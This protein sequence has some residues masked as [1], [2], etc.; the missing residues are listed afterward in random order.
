MGKALLL[1]V[2]GAGFALSTQIFSSQESEGRTALAQ[3]NYEEETIAREIAVSAFNVGM[4]DIRERGGHLVA[5][6]QD[7]NGPDF[8]GR[9]GTYTS[10]PYAGS[11][12]TVRAVLTSGQSV[13]LVSTGHTGLDAAT[14]RYRSSY[15]MH[16]EYRLSVLTARERALVNVN[17]IGSGGSYCSAIFYQAFTPG[18]APGTVPVPQLLFPSG[19]RDRR[20]SL[21]AREIQV[22]PGT[23]M[24]F[25]IAVDENCSDRPP[26]MTTCESRAYARSF[27]YDATQYNHT[28]NA[29]VVAAGSLNEAREDIW[30]FIEQ[31]PDNRQ[32][33]RIGWEDIHRS[34]WKTVPPGATLNEL[35]LIKRNGYDGAGWPT[36][37]A[38]GYRLLRDFG[39]KPDFDDQVI[40]VALTPLLSADGQ[41]RAAAEAAAEQTCNPTTTTPTTTTPTPPVPTPPTPAPGTTNGAGCNC[42]GNKKVYV[43]H[44]PP[45]NESNEQRICISESGWTNGH[46]GR[47][48]DYLICRGS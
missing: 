22:E 3:R 7:F 33:W 28:H 36:V 23:Q 10:G 39:S 35:Q 1:I 8:R 12:Y 27:Q 9:S 30:A 18:M 29:L 42:Q 5:A 45:G 24:N 38:M 2:L 44:R 43:L 46:A 19:N 20:G 6:V 17:F 15:T 14:G 26:S 21:P 4:G 48:N 11:R 34:D 13:R 25:F 41:A 47:H 37:D 31:H 16:D 32:R 40:E